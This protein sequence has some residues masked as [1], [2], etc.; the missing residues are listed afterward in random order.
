MIEII[1]KRENDNCIEIRTSG[2]GGGIKGSDIVCAGVSAIIH[3]MI[4]GLKEM[5]RQYPES[6]RI[7]E[8]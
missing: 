7:I 4:L 2:H 1:I 8:E 3:T 5:G 6:I